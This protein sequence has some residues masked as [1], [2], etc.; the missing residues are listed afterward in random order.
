V[1]RDS[2]PVWS[3]DGKRVAFLRTPTQENCRCSGRAERPAVVDPVG[4]GRQR[5]GREVWK[6]K[7]GR[8]KRL[9][10]RRRREPASLG[11]GDRIVFPWEEDGWTHLY[12]VAAAGGEAALLTPGDFEVEYASLGQDGKDAVYASNQG[13]IDRR[14]LWKVAASGGIPESLTRE[15]ALSG[16]LSARWAEARSV[17]RFRCTTAGRP[18]VLAG[19]RRIDVAPGSLGAEFPRGRLI[20]PQAVTFKAADGI[21]I[22]GQLFL[23]GGIQPGERRPAV[24]FLHGGSRRQ[25]LLGWHGMAL[26]PQHIRLQSVPGEPWLHRALGQLSQAGPDTYEFRE[27]LRYAPWGPASSTTCWGAGR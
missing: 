7:P 13:D 20:V 19:G 4:G 21:E 10:W 23:A 16:H 24:I 2:D 22:R 5:N 27:A 11:R 25:M 3:A 8:G 18:F 12:S 14:H 9:P 26:L 1:D 15:T 6:A 17:P